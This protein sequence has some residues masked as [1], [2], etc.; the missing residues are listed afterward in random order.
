MTKLPT[1]LLILIIL[2]A[3]VGCNKD[4]SADCGCGKNSEVVFTIEDADE[5]EGNLYKAIK[6]TNPN[7]PDFKFAIWF[8]E[9][10]CINCVHTFFICNDSLLSGFGEIPPYP[11]VRIKFSGQA[12]DL[13]KQPH[14]LA[15][16]TYNHIIITRIE[17]Q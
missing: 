3:F 4:E 8:T 6:T 13:C 15:D 5:Q 7:T 16:Y 17:Q 2:T 10:G 12:K 1:V 9:S 14:K 11:G